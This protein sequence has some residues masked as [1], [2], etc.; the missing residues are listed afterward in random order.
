MCKLAVYRSKH[1]R[2]EKNWME[3]QR[4]ASRA[5]DKRVQALFAPPTRRRGH[6]ATAMD[7]L[8]L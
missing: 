1:K 3:E 6:V 5:C 4:G 7:L 2:N 8:P